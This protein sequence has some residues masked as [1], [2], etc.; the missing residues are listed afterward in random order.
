MGNSY[1]HKVPDLEA[2]D[3]YF[4]SQWFWTHSR[5]RIDAIDLWISN[6]E[7][8]GLLPHCHPLL[9]FWYRWKFIQ[10]LCKWYWLNSSWMLNIGDWYSSRCLGDGL[11][12]LERIR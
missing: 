1:Y 7:H 8:H 4:P 6:R 11:C 10:L 3:A 9:C 12:E 5:K 2:A